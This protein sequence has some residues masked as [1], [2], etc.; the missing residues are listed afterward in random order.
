MA[1]YTYRLTYGGI[2]I[3]L[4]LVGVWFCVFR[5]LDNPRTYSL[6]GCALVIALLVWII[7]PVLLSD[8]YGISVELLPNRD[9]LLATIS[10]SFLGSLLSA[11][12]IAL[13]VSVIFKTAHHRGGHGHLRDRWVRLSAV[14]L[15]VVLNL[16]LSAWSVMFEGH[17]YRLAGTAPY[18]LFLTIATSFCLLRLRMEVS[19][20]F[21]TI[22][23]FL[24]LLAGYVQPWLARQIHLLSYERITEYYEYTN[25]MAYEYIPGYLL[26]RT[27]FAVSLV[28]ESVPVLLLAWA[29]FQLPELS[30]TES[31]ASVD[32][33]GG[34]KP[35]AMGSGHESRDSPFVFKQLLAMGGW[36][37]TVSIGSTA[38][39]IAVMMGYMFLFEA[40][41]PYSHGAWG[42]TVGMVVIFVGVVP[43]FLTGAVVGVVFAAKRARRQSDNQKNLGD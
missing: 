13:M 12:P 34:Q 39:F 30:S 18:L 28:G 42:P 3:V 9:D 6:S 20:V 36:G 43:V 21:A 27:H 29:V 37:M 38:L 22:A 23:L 2:Y 26:A 8:G 32:S 24:A 35:T 11:I 16:L 14:T 41:T 31:G 40:S 33:N 4:L 25:Q 15:V 19:G 5:R 7:G 17:W 1:D 10:R